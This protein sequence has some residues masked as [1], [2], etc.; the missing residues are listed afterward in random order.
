MDV[1]FLFA[2]VVGFLLIGVPI[3]VSLGLSSIIFLMIY[4]DSLAGLHRPDPVQRLRRALHPA[5][6]PLLHPCLDLHVDGR[7][8]APH[9]P[10]RHRLR[11]PFPGRPGDR[12][13]V[14]LHAVRRAFRFVARHRGGDRHDRHRR[15]APGRLHQGLRR[16]RDLQ[17]RHPRHPDPAL[18][19]HGGL[20]LGG[21][22]LGRPQCSWPA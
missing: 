10:L 4:S 12:R 2:M 9:H 16:R 7:R 17:R 19:R 22:R 15:H 6:H 8:G 14:R 3:A 20:R 21:R 1:I 11:R 5:R 18:D 13:R